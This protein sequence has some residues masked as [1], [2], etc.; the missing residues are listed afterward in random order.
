MRM[1]RRAERV[2]VRM[3]NDLPP[4]SGEISCPPV[5]A[6]GTG[7]HPVVA[8]SSDASQRAQTQRVVRRRWW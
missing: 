7:S 8:Q 1:Y 3:G 6:Q 2:Q 5:L 4:V